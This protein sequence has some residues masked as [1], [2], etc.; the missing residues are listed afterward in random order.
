MGLKRDL[1]IRKRNKAEDRLARAK[2]RRLYLGDGA[3][4]GMIAAAKKEVQKWN[5]KFEDAIRRLEEEVA[6]DG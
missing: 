6:K 3:P 5:R 2:E 4:A 1:L